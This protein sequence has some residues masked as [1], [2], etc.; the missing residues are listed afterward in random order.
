MGLH[1][2]RDNVLPIQ[3]G[4]DLRDTFVRTNGCTPRNPPEPAHG[5]L[6]HIIT[7]YSGCRSGYP[8]VWAAF[9]GAGHDPGPIDGTTGDGWRTWTSAAVWQFFTQFGSNQPPPP[10]SGNQEIVGQQSGRCL[11]INN[12]T[13]ANGTQAQLWDCNGASNQRWTYSAGKQLVVYGNKCLG[14]GQGA[15]NGTPAAI[16]D[17]SGQP[18]QQWNVNPDGTI[19]AAQ[20]GLCLDAVGQGTG[21]GTKVQLWSCSGGAN[22]H[23]RLQN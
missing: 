9:D 8:V 23:W 16:W 21:N 10:Q 6:T 11:D 15:A 13:T 5:S 7:T 1:G 4:R 20:S 17:C 18:D 2:L 12:S 19:T 14:V 22:Q 3:S